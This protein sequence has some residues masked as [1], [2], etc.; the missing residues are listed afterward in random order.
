LRARLGAQSSLQSSYLL[1]RSGFLI[2]SQR[3]L[4]E[5]RCDLM[6]HVACRLYALHGPSGRYFLEPSRS[7]LC[8]A[9]GQDR[10]RSWWSPAHQR[11]WESFFSPQRGE[12]VR[13][14]PP[15]ET[16]AARS[17]TR[18]LR[19]WRDL[20]L[21]QEALATSS[22]PDKHWAGLAR[23]FDVL[24]RGTRVHAAPG[25]P[26]QAAVIGHLALC[27]QAGGW[28]GHWTEPCVARP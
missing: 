14:L 10:P 6:P 15:A 27:G 1:G 20:A 4:G 21:R 28:G 2:H 13:R 11:G 22:R 25:G 26:L 19:A 12:R 3:P 23:A 16:M 24:W 9:L 17:W 18:G 5:L 7:W 8:L